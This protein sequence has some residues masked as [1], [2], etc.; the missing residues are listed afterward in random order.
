MPP[1]PEIGGGAKRKKMK[2]DSLFITIVMVHNSFD[3]FFTC[4]YITSIQILKIFRLVIT[5]VYE[6]KGYGIMETVKIYVPD[7]TGW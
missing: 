5:R 7:S 2:N 4:Q 6:S 3:M 1:L